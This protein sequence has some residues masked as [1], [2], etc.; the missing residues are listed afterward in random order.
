MS[1]VLIWGKKLMGLRTTFK[2]MLDSGSPCALK[3]GAKSIVNI[4]TLVSY[5]VIFSQVTI[6][7][8]QFKDHVSNHW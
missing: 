2:T 6:Q 1:K 8:S 7:Q 4:T 3:S 5:A